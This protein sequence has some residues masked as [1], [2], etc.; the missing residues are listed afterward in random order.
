MKKSLASALGFAVLGGLLLM[1]SGGEIRAQSREPITCGGFYVVARGDT[2]HD[3]SV[4]AY[5]TANYLKIFDANRDVLKSVAVI[6]VGDRL[7]IPCLDGTG[8]QSRPEA[9]AT[10][11]G[12]H[13]PQAATSTDA[14]D[15]S[16][17]A[18]AAPSES[19]TRHEEPAVQILVLAERPPFTGRDL[20]EGGMVS[21]IIG[22]SIR[23]VPGAVAFELSYIGGQETPLADVPALGYDA[24]HP[25]VR[26]DCDRLAIL[27]GPLQRLC[28]DFVWSDPVAEFHTRFY[29]ARGNELIAASD[30]GQL[31]GLRLCRPAESF[32]SDLEVEGLVEPNVDLI[33]PLSAA[34]CLRQLA[35]G[36][37]DVASV[38]GTAADRA[39]GSL[40]IANA[41]AE[42]ELFRR[43]TPL[44]VA[45]PK[46]DDEGV[47]FVEA[48][49][50]GIAVLRGS[51]ELQAVVEGY[52][53]RP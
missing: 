52:L 10:G 40:G 28:N 8:F 31:F 1:A 23:A 37:V 34:D 11:T 27:P 16:A 6:E 18:A 51:G 35:Q 29:V 38:S 20:P 53:K 41:V 24:A 46:D 49:N 26:P 30:P 3:I 44:R 50:R 21:E 14:T 39:I 48:L 13:I 47:A 2:L 9:L 45:A 17:V 43:S 4:R 15:G 12:G 36:A 19:A 22:R 33:Q 25:A 7:L 42:I 5:E 32:L